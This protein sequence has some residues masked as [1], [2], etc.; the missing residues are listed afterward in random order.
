MGQM[1]RNNYCWE[2]FSK[3]FSVNW[4]YGGEIF[5]SYGNHKIVIH[6]KVKIKDL[7]LNM[8]EKGC[9]PVCN[10]DESRIGFRTFKDRVEIDAK[11]RSESVVI[12]Y[13]LDF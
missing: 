9:M 6:T 12:N 7:W 3:D 5:L 2:V 8:D 1:R 4:F 13:F 10:G 11:I